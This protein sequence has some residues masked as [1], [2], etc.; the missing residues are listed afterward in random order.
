LN[1]KR[2]PSNAHRKAP[3][4]Y[5]DIEKPLASIKDPDMNKAPQSGRRFGPDWLVLK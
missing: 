5:D 4:E 3:K 1:L 2:I